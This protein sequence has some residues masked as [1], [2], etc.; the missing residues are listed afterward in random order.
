MN[1]VGRLDIVAS[2]GPS[3]ISSGLIRG[4]KQIVGSER[5]IDEPAQLLTYECDGVTHFKTVPLAVV[6]PDTTEEVQRILRYCHEARIPVT[7]RGAGTCLSGGATAQ[8][9]GILVELARMRKILSIDDTAV[10][11]YGRA[12]LH[13]SNAL[14]DGPYRLFAL[15]L[16][17]SAAKWEKPVPVRVRAMVLAGNVLLVAGP[18]ADPRNRPQQSDEEQSALLLAISASDGSELARYQIDSSPVFDGMAAANGRLYL[19]LEN[20]RL[21]SMAEK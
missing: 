20:G 7:P 11:G 15:S 9:G 8:P 5:C 1:G 13:W 19:S 18:P 12:R 14:Q 17:E 16:G 3:G 2:M 4:L 10:Y 21:L 6:L